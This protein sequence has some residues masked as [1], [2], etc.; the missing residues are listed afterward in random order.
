[1]KKL[2]AP[3][4]T[5]THN[6]VRSIR[7]ESV[8]ENFHELYSGKGTL[9]SFLK[10]DCVLQ[11]PTERK[12]RFIFADKNVWTRTFRTND[13]LLIVFSIFY[14]L[15]TRVHFPGKSKFI[16]FV[17]IAL[18]AIFLEINSTL[19]TCTS[20]TEKLRTKECLTTASPI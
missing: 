5:I 14:L 10:R 17:L 19:L 9:L 18:S 11:R 20:T 15:S 13:M 2:G 6:T 8:V 4:F 7:R 1:L 16:V 3:V 12:S